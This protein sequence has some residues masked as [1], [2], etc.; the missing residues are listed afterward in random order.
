MAPISNTSS[1]IEK[2]I[3][4]VRGLTAALLATEKPGERA[5]RI[6]LTSAE[7]G[8]G[9]DALCQ[10]MAVHIA[11][12]LRRKCI[13]VE[14]RP[15]SARRGSRTSSSPGFSEYLA[16]EATLEDC[17]RYDD[18]TGPGRI[19]FGRKSGPNAVTF[20][21]SRL[22]KLVEE[23]SLEAEVI[24]FDVGDVHDAPETILLLQKMDNVVV[25]ASRDKADKRMLAQVRTQL[26]K[27]NVPL[28]GAVLTDDAR[29]F[30]SR[31]FGVFRRGGA[32]SN[33]R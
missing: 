13:L 15:A 31:L 11:R 32:G 10:A 4:H 23:V 30:W 2:A 29:S 1:R 12:T 24:I 22:A 33:P 9:T 28:L 5:F 27:A 21:S 18:P 26:E 16:D 25:V 8:Q 6:A 19:P 7:D 14:T 17:I 20:S 3:P